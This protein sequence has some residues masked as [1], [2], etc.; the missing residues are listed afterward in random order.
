[1][2]GDRYLFFLDCASAKKGIQNFQQV[3]HLFFLGLYKIFLLEIACVKEA[4]NTCQ[5]LQCI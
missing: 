5:G 3:Q 4:S 2:N 1:M